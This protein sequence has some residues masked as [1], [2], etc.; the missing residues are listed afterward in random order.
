MNGE[1]PTN[2]LCNPAFFGTLERWER[3][4]DVD[5]SGWSVIT[6]HFVEGGM[7]HVHTKQ[8]LI[9]VEPDVH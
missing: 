5:Q 4:D 7:V 3:V 6:L 9:W 2:A 1:P 8:P